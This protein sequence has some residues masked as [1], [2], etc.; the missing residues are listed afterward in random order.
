[1][2]VRAQ[3]GSLPSKTAMA[4]R[5][6]FITHPEVVVDPARPVTRWALSE[7]GRRRMIAFVSSGALAK[8]GSVFSSSE[9]KALDAAELVSHL[10]G[11]PISRAEDQPRQ[12]NFYRVDKASRRLLHDWVALPDG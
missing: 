10:K 2:R 6:L 5:L 9:Q 4:S 3:D 8:A 12:G 7:A 11:I 1:L